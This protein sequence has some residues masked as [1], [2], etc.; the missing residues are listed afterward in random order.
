MSP[1]MRA[2]YHRSRFRLRPAVITVSALM[3]SMLWSSI[4]PV[5]V[6]SGALLGWLI[7]VVFPLPPAH[8]TGRVRPLPLLHLVARLFADLTVSSVRMIKYAVMREVDLHASII[9]TDLHS[10]D[11]L[12]QVGVASMIS[13]VPGTVV[14]EVVRHPRRLYLHCLGMDQQD[15]DD[16]QAMVVGVERRLL[17]AMGS[18]E[19]LA[20]FEDAVA[21]PTVAPATDWDAEEADASEAEEAQ[22]ID[23]VAHGM[24]A[25]EADARADTR[26]GRR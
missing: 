7:G 1:T 13:L 21:T 9:R 25:G 26:G 24:G 8:W 3:W 6:L 12:Y 22:A 17:R 11:D 23:D 19:E 20:Q 18:D 5:V 10:D 14:V 16:V 2:R 15:A 4:S